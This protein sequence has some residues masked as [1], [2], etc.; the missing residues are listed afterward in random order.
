MAV[1]HRVKVLARSMCYRVLEMILQIITWLRA[2]LRKAVCRLRR[3]GARWRKWRAIDL[4]REPGRN[5]AVPQHL[6]LLLTDHPQIIPCPGPGVSPLDSRKCWA[7]CAGR[8]LKR[9]LL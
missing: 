9:I 4:H 2:W 1:K 5:T 8:R 7:K 6:V 3:G